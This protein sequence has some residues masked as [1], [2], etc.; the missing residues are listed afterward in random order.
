MIAAQQYFIEYG[1][2]MNSERL[3]NLLPFF[4]QALLVEQGL[5]VC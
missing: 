3:M 4:L 2:D 1:T 5:T